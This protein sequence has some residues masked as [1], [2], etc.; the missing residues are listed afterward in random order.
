MAIDAYNI[1]N[2]S[3]MNRAMHDANRCCSTK[4]IAGT[5]NF[6]IQQCKSDRVL[7]FSKDKKCS[8]WATDSDLE[9]IFNSLCKL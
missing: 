8:K 2:K 1:V 6:V 3:L 7:I 4:K 5:D 9:K